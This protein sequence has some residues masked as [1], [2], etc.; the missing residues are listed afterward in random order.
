LDPKPAVSPQQAANGLF[1]EVELRPWVE[2]F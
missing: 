1:L 2:K